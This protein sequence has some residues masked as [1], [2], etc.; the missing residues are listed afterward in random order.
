MRSRGLVGMMVL[1]VGGAA[2]G[3]APAEP[4][5]AKTWDLFA[6]GSYVRLAQAEAGTVASAGA[7]ECE[8]DDDVNPG[9]EADCDGVGCV[10]DGAAVYA[11]EV[12]WRDDRGEWSVLQRFL[13]QFG[14][15][16]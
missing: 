11:G 15:G 5:E 9:A 4:H 1:V 7:G 2:Y 16:L 14:N 12:V 6:G 13:S 3:Q 10:G 8:G